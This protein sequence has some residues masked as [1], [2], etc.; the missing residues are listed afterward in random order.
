[1]LEILSPQQLAQ[2]GETQYRNGQYE[3]AA[4][5]FEKAIQSYTTAGGH[6]DSSR[7]GE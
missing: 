3:E 5:S 7:N 1:M 4:A 6:I 2:S